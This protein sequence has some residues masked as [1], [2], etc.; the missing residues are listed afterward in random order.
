MEAV[1]ALIATLHSRFANHPLLPE[2]RL[3][4]GDLGISFFAANVRDALRALDSLR[5]PVIDLS[6]ARAALRDRLLGRMHALLGELPWRS[7]A[8]AEIGG[9]ETLLHGDLWTTN[10]LALP[11]ADGWQAHLMVYGLASRAALEDYF[12]SDARRRFMEEGSAF[13]DLMR[14]E[15]LW[16]TVA[17]ATR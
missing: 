5:T 9:P 17:A 7:R 3:Y 1:V 2:C 10:T 12:Q 15:R 6:D 8:L 11:T 16:G 13:R 14:A 4:G